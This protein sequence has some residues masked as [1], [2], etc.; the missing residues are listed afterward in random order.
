MA[1]KS[2]MI[3]NAFVSISG[4]VTSSLDG[5]RAQ[6]MVETVAVWLFVHPFLHSVEHITMELKMLIAEG[7]VVE[8]S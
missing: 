8:D 5:C 6:N 1:A 7:W 3:M 2:A 4:V